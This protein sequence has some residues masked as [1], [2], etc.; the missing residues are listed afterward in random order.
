MQQQVAE[1]SVD[2]ADAVWSVAWP[3][4]PASWRAMRVLGEVPGCYGPL[5][6]PAK[7]GASLFSPLGRLRRPGQLAAV[8]RSERRP[9]ALEQTGRV[10]EGINAACIGKG[11]RKK[12]G[13]LTCHLHCGQGE[14][15]GQVNH[16][17]EV[18]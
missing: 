3:H 5:I 4:Q 8:D 13:P 2:A 17:A 15:Q 6:V 16:P 11:R 14:S 9:S 10:L 12:K 1:N 7:V 18:R